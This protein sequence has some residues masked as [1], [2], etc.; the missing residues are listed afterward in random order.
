MLKL[1]KD[2]DLYKKYLI[3]IDKIIDE[4]DVSVFKKL[5][6]EVFGDNW[7]SN[8]DDILW[9]LAGKNLLSLEKNEKKFKIN[10]K[11]MQEFITK[12]NI[13]LEV[14]IILAPNTNLSI[15]TNKSKNSFFS[16]DIVKKRYKNLFNSN[17]FKF[18]PINYNE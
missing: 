3:F 5:V 4:T 9:F 6:V 10:K 11:L 17:N 1:L 7:K 12:E 14:K 15:N 13:A 2:K 8:A 18:S 16:K